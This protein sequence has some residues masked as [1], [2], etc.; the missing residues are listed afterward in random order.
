MKHPW[1]TA[2]ITESEQEELNRAMNRLNLTILMSSTVVLNLPAYIDKK[3]PG[4]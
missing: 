4:Q 1:C 3:C 2:I